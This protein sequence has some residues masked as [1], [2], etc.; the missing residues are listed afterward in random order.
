MYIVSFRIILMNEHLM[1]VI[2]ILSKAFQNEKINFLKFS[3][4][5]N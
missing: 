3:I 2:E 5:L 1:K 4:H